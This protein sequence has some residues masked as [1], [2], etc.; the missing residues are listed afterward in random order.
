[1]PLDSLLASLAARSLG[2][3]PN[4]ITGGVPSITREDIMALAAAANR[5]E[6]QLLMAKYVGD[7]AARVRVEKWLL[8]ISL[9]EWFTNP[10]FR[11]VQLE[12]QQ[13]PKL[14]RLAVKC[15][16]NPE[17]RDVAT[18]RSRATF[19]GAQIDTYRNRFE[20]HYAFLIGE[21]GHHERCALTAVKRSQN[22]DRKDGIV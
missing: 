11:T 16:M 6:F 2:A 5:L 15:W 14:S 7:E 3:D 18:K 22:Q 13:L 10:A 19:I 12:T 20:P 8:K 9:R 1:M 17:D 4:K 21:L